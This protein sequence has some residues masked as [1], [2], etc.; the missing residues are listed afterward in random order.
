MI[1][2]LRAE[3]AEMEID[4][5]KLQEKWLL[6]DHQALD[7]ANAALTKNRK[8]SIANVFSDKGDDPNIHVVNGTYSITAPW[9]GANSMFNM[10]KR[11]M[12]VIEDTR[13]EFEGQDSGVIK[14]NLEAKQKQANDATTKYKT[15]WNNWQK[16][17]DE[18]RI[19]GSHVGSRYTAWRRLE[20]LEHRSKYLAH[21]TTYENMYYEADSLIRLS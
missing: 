16:Y 15:N 19:S 13:A 9:T 1:T 11:D 20:R 14:R 8:V 21:Q 2:A 4:F 18:A 3:I 6:F 12:R 17:Y 10:M 7:N 5:I